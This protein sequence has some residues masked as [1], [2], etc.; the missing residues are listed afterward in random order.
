MSLK[1]LNRLTG[2]RPN[3]SVKQVKRFGHRG[4]HTYDVIVV[5]GGHAG[6]EACSAA[7]RMGASSLLVTHSKSSV[8]KIIFYITPKPYKCNKMFV[9]WLR[10]PRRRDVLQPVVRRNRQ[11][12]FDER[13]RRVGRAVRQ[14]LRSFR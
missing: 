4:Q 9:G 12:T 11:R 8:G 3:G 2:N 7:A 13:D 14:N 10:L 5:G 1:L 6:A